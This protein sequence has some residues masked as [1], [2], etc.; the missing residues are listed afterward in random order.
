MSLA[1][2]EGFRGQGPLITTV[3][4]FTDDVQCSDFKLHPEV[5]RSRELPKVEYLRYRTN[6]LPRHT[7]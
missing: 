2:G 6:L 3:S 1:G 5:K 4:N 7:S